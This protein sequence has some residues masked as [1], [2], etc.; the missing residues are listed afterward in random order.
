M[1]LLALTNRHQQ[2][3]GGVYPQPKL[4]GPVPVRNH[5][6]AVIGPCRVPL[7]NGLHEAQE[8]A[9]QHQMENDDQHQAQNQCQCDASPKS[10]QGAVQ[11]V[12]SDR[13]GVIVHFEVTVNGIWAGAAVQ[14]FAVFTNAAENG[15]RNG[16]ECPVLQWSQPAAQLVAIRV[17]NTGKVDGLQCEQTIDHLLG[18]DVIN[19]E[20]CLGCGISN[21]RHGLFCLA[22]QFQRHPSGVENNL[23]GADQ[24]TCQEGDNQHPTQD[25]VSQ[26]IFNFEGG[27]HSESSGSSVRIVLGSRHSVSAHHVRQYG[28]DF[29]Q[30][31][32]VWTIFS[33][34]HGQACIDLLRFRRIWIQKRPPS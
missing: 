21:H 2:V 13:G 23:N 32:G 22:L 4:I 15:V 6:K 14:A 16:P 12:L 25:S 29:L 34:N 10:D 26:V 31:H 19:A 28:S 33:K 11:P 17:R 30:L 3:I 7:T 1:P 5:Y 9:S 20:H 24:N 8:R 27:L 18:E